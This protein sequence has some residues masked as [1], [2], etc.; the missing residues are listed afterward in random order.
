[1]K[2]FWVG[3]NKRV[4][5]KLL[6]EDITELYEEVI[7]KLSQEETLKF[8]AKRHDGYMSF[9]IFDADNEQHAAEIAVKKFFKDSHLEPVK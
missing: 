5:D 9:F 7:R 4:T 3:V 6:V 2:R 8:I 1:M